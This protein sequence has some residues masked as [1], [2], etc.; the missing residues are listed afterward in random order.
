MEG[1]ISLIILV[2]FKVM[3]ICFYTLGYGFKLSNV[4][5]KIVM[6]GIDSAV[7]SFQT[8]IWI[9]KSSYTT[10]EK[11]MYAWGFCGTQREKLVRKIQSQ[12]MY[13]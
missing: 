6:W 7:A 4:F 10:R 5:I 13:T 3:E 8:G 1:A 12:R 2:F 11:L 9:L